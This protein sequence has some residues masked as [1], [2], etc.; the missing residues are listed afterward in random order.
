[1]A[2]PGP[3]SDANVNAP[4][5]IED[6]N[7]SNEED[8]AEDW[9]SC[10]RRSWGSNSQMSF[11]S[12]SPDEAESPESMNAQETI[13]ILPFDKEYIPPEDCWSEMGASDMQE[14]EEK[15]L[16]DEAMHELA[17][18][19]RDVQA[20]RRKLLKELNATASVPGL[21]KMDKLTLAG[22]DGKMNVSRNEEITESDDEGDSESDSENNSK[23]ACKDLSKPDAVGW[24]SAAD[25]S[26][27]LP[28]A[29]ESILE[30]FKERPHLN[31]AECEEYCLKTY[32]MM[33]GDGPSEARERQLNV[34]AYPSE[35][36]FRNS[37]T[38]EIIDTTVTN[39]DLMTQ[40]YITPESLDEDQL[41]QAKEAYGDFVPQYTYVGHMGMVPEHPAELFVWRIVSPAGRPIAANRYR[42]GLRVNQDKYV[43][44]LK[45]FVDLVCQPLR[46]A[47]GGGRLHDE[48]DWPQVLHN[49]LLDVFNIIVRPDWSGIACVLL[50]GAP[51]SMTLPF[52][53]SLCGLLF[54][55]EGGPEDGNPISKANPS[56]F[57][58]YSHE[59]RELERLCMY[60]LQEKIPALADDPQ[61]WHRLFGAMNQGIETAADWG[62]EVDRIGY[63]K[64]LDELRWDWFQWETKADTPKG[65]AVVAC[66]ESGR[67]GEKGDMN[68]HMDMDMDMDRE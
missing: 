57:G 32:L 19:E 38:V 51:P 16:D 24:E 22:V 54:L 56:L 60:Y 64:Q 53:A 29:I 7:M 37:Y 40:F 36:Q 23:S 39:P 49:H 31:R 46:L 67:G 63:Q 61:A 4:D 14:E 50:W 33:E 12:D 10:D 47:G 68:M 62:E 6:D 18:L 27:L 42:L 48:K 2:Y 59:A 45:Q 17:E 1:M 34:H 8:S 21:E 11:R 65:S 44:I 25:G 58:T 28:E 43:G 30:F 13:P 52:G 20:K 26:R 3:S 9:M 55:L 35:S 15:E 66:A 41:A 5:E